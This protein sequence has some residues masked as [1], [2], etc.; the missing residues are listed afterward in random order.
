MIREI[1]P[2][3][4][5]VTTQYDANDRIIARF[6][7][8]GNKSSW[9]YDK[10]NRVVKK[11]NA[12]G[13]ATQMTYDANGNILQE[14]DSSGA[15]TTYAYDALDRLI[16]TTLPDGSVTL[17]DYD[18][19]GRVTSTVGPRGEVTKFVYDD[20][21]QLIQVTDP[22]LGVYLQSF[23]S[24]GNLISTTDPRGN[25]TTRA[26]DDRNR[27]FLVTDASGFQTRFDLDSVSRIIKLTDQVGSQASFEYDARGKMISMTAADGGISRY[28][29]DAAGN[30]VRVEDPL[31]RVSLTTYDALDRPLTTV[32]PKGATTS[33]QYDPVGNVTH[34]TDAS[35]NTTQWIYDALN[36]VSQSIDPLGGKEQFIY[37][38]VALAC[39]CVVAN[40]RG[41]L[42]EY[43]DKLGRHTVYKYD[44]R[45]RNTEVI[46]RNAAEVEVD[47]IQ[48]TYD[49][50]SNLKSIRDSDSQLSFTYDL[51]S[52]LITAD[53]SGTPGVRPVTLTNTWDAAGNRTRVAD[54]D[55]V[56][57]SSTY[58]P[59]NLLKTHTWS[60]P[61]SGNAGIAPARVDLIYNGRGQATQLLRSSDVVGAQVVSKTIRTYD[62]VGRADLIS[63]RSAI[64]SVMAQFDSDWNVADELAAWTIDGKQSTYQYDL[65]GQLT[66]ADHQTPGLAN[67]SFAYDATGNR[68][69]ASK[70][71]GP[72]NRLLS[73]ERFDYTFDSEGNTLSKLERSS[74][75]EQRFGY[76]HQNRMTHADTRSRS[77]ALLSSVDYR[78][79]ALGRRLARTADSDG[80]GPL[81]LTVQNFVYDGSDVWLDASGSGA[82]T[83]RYM[84]GDNV[85]EPLARYRPGEGVAWYL[86]DHLGS[87]RAIADASGAIIDR[88]TYDSFGA[89]VTESAP[90]AGDRIK[91]TGREWDA[92][93]GLYYYRSR[94]YDPSSGRF[95]SEDQIGFAAGDFNLHRYVGNMPGAYRD[96]SGNVTMADYGGA[97]G[98]SRIF[99]ALASGFTGFTF[100]YTCGYLD[101]FTKQGLK[102]PEAE[103][104]AKREGLLVGSIDFSASITLNSKAMTGPPIYGVALFASGTLG[105]TVAAKIATSQKS[106]SGPTIIASNI[107]TAISIVGGYKVGQTAG[108][109]RLTCRAAPNSTTGGLNLWKAGSE[110]ALRA[111]GWRKGDYFFVFADQGSTKANWAMNSSLLRKAMREGKPIFD[112]YIDE[113]GNLIPATGFLNL[114]R[115]LLI[116][117][118]WKFNQCTGAWHPPTG[119]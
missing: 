107:C 88:I 89:I 3:G 66:T 40:G 11:I 30:R 103:F 77:G 28:E 44:S 20:A 34:L 92:E 117:R 21:N 15:T 24:V 93:A 118:S 33:M 10:N 2:L 104:Y 102:G 51:N 73:D 35:G 115:N 105:L 8:N 5:S 74:G 86:T 65:T 87:I 12:L 25:K 7:E 119:N 110:Q 13:F 96:P 82:I 57:V 41:H 46:Y 55:G 114:E 37:D 56:S 4:N 85:D 31:G 108:R 50:S 43:I 58:D 23:D 6:D 69:G 18:A 49:A 91:F 29:Y 64:D 84:H 32:D 17:T 71:V 76:D 63:H 113:V 9:E 116:N 112:S 99:V 26:F 19:V 1:D 106:A 22:M 62:P 60:G 27:L 61:S 78:F 47:R 90:A 83:A 75:N 79:D 70:S 81:A 54:G 16:S 101:A 42:S 53:N 36:R 98:F 111:K 39:G 52:R 94:M 80:D 97:L 72:N 68:T 95:L 67:E 109:V 14:I 48:L 45:N 38:N 100:G 59:R